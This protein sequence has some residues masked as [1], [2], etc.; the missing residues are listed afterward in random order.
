MMNLNKTTI[1]INVEDQDTMYQVVM[2]KMLMEKL[3]NTNNL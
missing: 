2:L 1:A 3:F